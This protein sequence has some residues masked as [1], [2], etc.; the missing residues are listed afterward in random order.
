MALPDWSPV[1]SPTGSP[2]VRDTKDANDGKD[3][4]SRLDRE[5][6]A[7]REL[8]TVYRYLSGLALQDADLAGVV[9]LISDR[10][11]ATVAV[12]TQLM[13][14]LTA[15]A[16]GVSA[17]KAAVAVRE[18]VVHPR[19]G[20]VLRASRLSQR[21][22]RLPNVGGIPAVIVAPILVGDEVPS[23][24]ITIDPAD[25]IFGEDMSLLVTEHAATICG[26]I[27]GRER[28]VAAA[29]R[30][31]RD[32]LVEG[33]LLG[34]GRDQSDTGRWAAH[35]GYDPARDHNVMAVAFDLPAPVADH[36]DA[37]AQRQ[38]IW[39]S[40]EH[41]VAT[42]APDAIV[43]ARESEV[44]I[45][46][47]APD[48]RGPAAMDAR[49]LAHACLAR[50]AELFPA[51]RV[52][53]GIGGVCRDP[54]EVARSYAQAQRTTQTLRRLG[55][56]GTVSRVRRPRHPP[57]A[58]PGARP[59]RAQVVR[60]RRAGQAGRPRAGTQ[61]GVPDH[62]GLL[63]PGKQQ[64]AAG[65]PHPARPSEHGGLPGQ[66]DRGD[67]RVAAGQ[68]HRPAHRPGGAGDPRRARRGAMT[69][70]EP[71][72][73][74]LVCDGAMGTML[75]AAGA[76]LDRSLPELNLS[77]PGLVSTIHES[78][79]DAGADI[80]QTNTFGANRL[81]LGDHGFPDKVD[82][83]NRAGVRIARAAQDQCEREVLVA[84]SVSPAVTASQRRRIGSAERTEVIR[85]QVQSL[86][87]GRGVD[88]LILETFGYLDELVEAVCAVADLTDVPVIA[89]ATFADDAY[90]LG[91]ETPREVATVLS[92]LPVAMLGTNCTIGPQRMLTVA[93]DLVRYASVPVSA[94]PNAGQ[95]R[96]TGPRSFEFAVD[97][98]YFAR[99]IRRFAEAGVSLVGGCCGTTPTHIRAA[100]G[101]VRDSS[102]AAD[103]EAATRRSS[104]PSRLTVARAPALHEPARLV[105]GTLADQLASRRFIVAAAIATP[106]GGFGVRAGDALDAAAV[107]AAHGIGV[108][109]VQPP[110]TART[111][112]DALDMALRLQ[113]HA[114]VE[115]VAT[116]TTWDK[117]IMT[118]QADLLGAHALGLRSVISATG[119]PPVRGDYPAVD[120]IWEV[121]SL[122]L[123]A[124]LAGLNAGRDSNGLALTT[125]T[126]FCIGARVNPGARGYGR[127]DRPGP[128]QGPG[129]CALPGQPPRLRA[130]LA[131]TRGDGARNEGGRGGGWDS[132]AAVGR[133]AA[134]LRGGGLPGP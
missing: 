63:L 41:F 72:Q 47:A 53:I 77:D 44:V 29:A 20:Q 84:G 9:Q 104:R 67:H 127:R 38:R 58:A 86:T 5:N 24:L 1:L 88:L 14:V 68:L 22:L 115:T 15:A 59:G 107:L 42:R 112:L 12:V 35:L 95:P 64:P 50:L 7:L 99:Y 96:R 120:G 57:A 101:A 55:R 48:E 23:Y 119:S 8:V 108:F 133:P 25:N 37:A 61:V 125:R 113:Q 89:Q 121:D 33:L 114:G 94:Q 117:T 74:I 39:E 90:T 97:G 78:Y 124:L 18:H 19:L 131:A 60:R 122:G 118:L 100:A 111:H 123:I 56:A 73:R 93:E 85:E 52:V 129:R 105:T 2:P 11:T 46:T 91:G 83:I 17:D 92:G 36:T 132:A 27:L 76:A 130:G 109:A 51:A 32:D 126:S 80:I 54:R 49:R 110:E 102:E 69:A 98:G 62:A 6:A 87:S 40:V 116:V 128:G 28:V 71:G 3:A 21:A 66:A 103:P 70:F 45:V 82:E 10:M 13:D 4:S 65:L 75:H 30:R 106:A 16:P 34:R 31:V 79:L 134:Q 81:W 43:S 26:V